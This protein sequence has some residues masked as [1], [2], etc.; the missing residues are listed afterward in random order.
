MFRNL[1]QSLILGLLA[2]AGV[3]GQIVPNPTNTTNSTNT[4][5]TTN[6]TTSNSPAVQSLATALINITQVCKN[7]QIPVFKFE[8]G[9]PVNLTTTFNLSSQLNS[10]SVFQFKNAALE[11]NCF[12]VSYL[13]VFPNK[14][15]T[16]TLNQTVTEVVLRV[17]FEKADTKDTYSL[18]YPVTNTNKDPAAQLSLI[19][20]TTETTSTPNGMYG[21]F[22]SPN[23]FVAIVP[24]RFDYPFG[25]STIANNVC[26]DWSALNQTFFRY[27]CLQNDNESFEVYAFETVTRNIAFW[28][29]IVLM[30]TFIVSS[31]F[32]DED[33]ELEPSIKD[34]NWMAHSF[35][36]L[37]L[38]SQE[39]TFPRRPRIALIFVTAA[40]I[41]WYNGIINFRHMNMPP[42]SDISLVIRLVVLGVTSAV[43]GLIFEF[44]SAIFIVV[45]YRQH[46]S[47]VAD[48]K[49]E[50][51]HH[52][53]KQKVE[54]FEESTF[55]SLHLFY[56]Q[57]IIFACFFFM[58]PI[59]WIY[60]LKT[61]D[62]AYW[63]L[64]GVIG[65]CWK[66]LC[67]DVVLA[68]LAKVSFIKRVLYFRGTIPDVDA[69]IGYQ[70]IAKW[71]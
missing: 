12:Q 19:L 53:N 25:N 52:S 46:A 13:W 68:A 20:N 6:Q 51:D 54:R 64:Q 33:V 61:E 50:D 62:Q 49:R 71:I 23:A 1:T 10:E 18:V 9:V 5:N 2:F 44:F 36:S 66:Y 31:N 26:P 45:Y 70:K 58:S 3:L 69:M 14:T 34:N 43:F 55:E 11:N 27:N 24:R 29:W 28:L 21:Y 32:F 60:F 57:N 65:L 37:H 40:S 8:N 42:K 48:F 41:F 56:F 39:Q 67:F 47:F 17:V 22:P 16:R 38:A 35:V 7:Y 63:L 59:Y 30:L 15:L 4:T